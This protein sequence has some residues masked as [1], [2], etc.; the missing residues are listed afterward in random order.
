[1][2]L[3][4]LFSIAAIILHWHLNRQRN[5][6]EASAEEELIRRNRSWFA[7]TGK[8]MVEIHFLA[9][10]WPEKYPDRLSFE[11]EFDHI[12]FEGENPDT[13]W[14][15]WIGSG[16]GLGFV[17]ITYETTDPARFLV[18]ARQGLQQLEMPSST[19]ILIS[20][21]GGNWSEHKVYDS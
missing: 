10:D 7:Q 13:S 14:L 8:Y 18:V 2:G 19:K 11:D 20:D 6:R 1:M 21:A 16:T 9:K 15:S 17:D 4:A 3:A 5:L 12:L